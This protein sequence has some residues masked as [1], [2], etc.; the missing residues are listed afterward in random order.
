MKVIAALCYDKLTVLNLSNCHISDEALRAL[1]Q[2]GCYQLVDLNVSYTMVTDGGVAALCVGKN[3]DQ[4]G[5]PNLR[6]LQLTGT[7]ITDRSLRLIGGYVAEQDNVA[8][9]DPETGLPHLLILHIWHCNSVTAGKCGAA[10][11]PTPV[12]DRS[13]HE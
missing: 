11:L 3:S 13:E 12:L 9:F 7:R 1:S 2:Y 8:Q 6:S 10:D 4:G 5:C